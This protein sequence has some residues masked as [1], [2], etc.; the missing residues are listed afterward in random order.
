MVIIDQIANEV[1]TMPGHDAAE[2]EILIAGDSS[3]AAS[4]A[5]AGGNQADGID[6]RNAAF[7]RAQ[8]ASKADMAV[9][10]TFSFSFSSH[11]CQAGS[12]VVAPNELV[13][14]VSRLALVASDAVLLRGDDLWIVTL[15]H[16]HLTHTTHTHTHFLSPHSSLSLLNFHPG[17]EV[18]SKG[19]KACGDDASGAGQGPSSRS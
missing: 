2:D 17:C 15:T 6:A 3:T 13:L 16:T 5:I 11:A 12:S 9:R 18:H 7:F 19:G 4:H 14:V 1:Y 8:K 10:N